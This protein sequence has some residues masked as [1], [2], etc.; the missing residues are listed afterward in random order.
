MMAAYWPPAG[1][2]SGTVMVNS[3]SR[4]SL[5]ATVPVGSEIVIHSAILE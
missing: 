3:T 5:G 4:A 1:A 2:S